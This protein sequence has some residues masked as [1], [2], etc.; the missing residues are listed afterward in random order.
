[1]IDEF[2]NNVVEF[3]W[4]SNVL[5]CVITHVNKENQ[6]IC[7]RV[8]PLKKKQDGSERLIRII[9]DSGELMDF[10]IQYDSRFYLPQNRFDKVLF[11]CSE[12]TIISANK[13]FAK[14]PT[15]SSLK[16]QYEAIYKEIKAL[17]PKDAKEKQK[18]LNQLATQISTREC[19]FLKEENTSKH[20]SSKYDRFRI[21]PDKKGI[22]S[23][24]HGG[25]CSGK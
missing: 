24:V 18:A 22:S 2:I 8:V 20:K 6:A 5:F 7:Y 3:T 4:K 16:E 10:Q 13:E 9:N 25:G 17:P 1:M 15:L 23:I 19:L 12:E 14:L 21:I 11:R